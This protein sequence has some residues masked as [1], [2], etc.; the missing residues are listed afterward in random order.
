MRLRSDDLE[1]READGEI[2]VL[3]RRAGRY[4][5][6]GGSAATLW[7]LLT[8]GTN[9][10]ELASCLAERYGIAVAEARSDTADFARQ[11]MDAGLLEA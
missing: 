8:A 6:F 4:F 3:D 7:P 1:W 11:L 10:D 5:A 2:L 9:A